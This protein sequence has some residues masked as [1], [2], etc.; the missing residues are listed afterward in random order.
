MDTEQAADAPTL[1]DLRGR[2]R[3]IPWYLVE[4]TPTERWGQAD[5]DERERVLREHLLWQQ[6]LERT[7]VLVLAG[8]V[9]AEMAPGAGLAVV[10]A[11]SRES[12]EELAAT[13]PFAQVGLRTNRVR[14]WTVNEGALTVSIRLFDDACEL[15]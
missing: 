10:R 13:E 4:M 14:S 11:N 1:D 5:R 8:P 3:R 2:A 15:R 9:D 12:V 7:G 6:R